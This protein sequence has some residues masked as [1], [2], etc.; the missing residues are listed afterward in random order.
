VGRPAGFTGDAS[1]LDVGG[2]TGGTV[3]WYFDE[4]PDAVTFVAVDRQVYVSVRVPSQYDAQLLTRLAPA[5]SAL[6][7]RSPEPLPVPTLSPPG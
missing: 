7:Y 5:V 2:P 1:L 3:A 4:R 6:P